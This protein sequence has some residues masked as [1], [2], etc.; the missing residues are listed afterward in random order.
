MDIYNLILERTNLPNTQIICI[1]LFISFRTLIYCDECH[2]FLD[3]TRSE[4]SKSNLKFDFSDSRRKQLYKDV[5]E[6][7]KQKGWE[8]EVSNLVSSE[9]NDYYNNFARLFFIDS[10]EKFIPSIRAAILN[11]YNLETIDNVSI[12]LKIDKYKDLQTTYIRSKTMGEGIADWLIN[13]I[14]KIE[15]IPISHILNCAYE[16]DIYKSIKFITM[17]IIK[18]KCTR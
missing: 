10:G 12:K 2:D 8:N 17:G 18:K 15:S 13:N 3:P 11:K 16:L 14:F 6:F 7:I 9:D 4:I 5:I 1:V